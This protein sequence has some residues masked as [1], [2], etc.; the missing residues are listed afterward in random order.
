M[1]RRNLFAIV[2]FLLLV[3]VVVVVVIVF[4]VVV[5]DTVVIILFVYCNYVVLSGP[6]KTNYHIRV[7]VD[8]GKLV[9]HGHHGHQIKGSHHVFSAIFS[10]LRVSSSF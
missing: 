2:I 9:C 1:T 10:F 3:D 5:A 8:R 7:R 4:D 6:P